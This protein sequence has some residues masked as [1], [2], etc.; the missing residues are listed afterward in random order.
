MVLN[1]SIFS[2]WASDHMSCNDIIRLFVSMKKG[3]FIP[4]LQGAGHTLHKD[5]SH[6]FVK[7]LRAA[8]LKLKPVSSNYD[9]SNENS[10]SRNC[11]AW[12]RHLFKLF[13]RFSFGRYRFF[14]SL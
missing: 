10:F 8:F 5:M 14:P 1:F 4:M 12:S 2:A 6:M 11:A 3:F 13:E 7:E 9:S